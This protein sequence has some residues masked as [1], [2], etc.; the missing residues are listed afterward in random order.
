MIAA[1]KPYLHIAQVYTGF[2]VVFIRLP[3]S[4][5]RF[6]Q[7]VRVGDLGAFHDAMATFSDGFKTDKTCGS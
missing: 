6:E 4:D 7:A 3:F 5:A 1:L 2:S